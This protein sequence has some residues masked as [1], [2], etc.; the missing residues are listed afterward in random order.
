MSPVKDA[1]PDA[2]SLDAAFAEAMGAPARPK[3]PAAPPEIDP[4]APHGRDAE[5]AALAPH[6]YNKDGSIRKSAAGRKSKDE[7]ARTTAPDKPGEAKPEAELAKP[8]EYVQDL[9]GTADGLWMA[10]SMFGK[11]AP[12]IPV[13]GPKLPALKI[14]AQAAVW[15]ATKDRMVAAVSLAAEHNAA[16]A[17]FARKLKGGDATWMITC[18]TLAMPLISLSGMVWAKDADAQLKQAE[19]PTLAELAARNE[20]TLQSTIA[21]IIQQAKTAAEVETLVTVATLNEQ[22]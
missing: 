22:S 7:Q 10:I 5:G 13:I 18:A 21:E 9:A 11:A 3:E 17:R 14:Q 15:F 16:A 8:G 1:D 4:D 12:S 6:G 20:A 19:Q 2:V